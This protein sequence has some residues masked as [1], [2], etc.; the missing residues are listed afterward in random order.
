VVTQLNGGNG[1]L[2]DN[3]FAACQRVCIEPCLAGQETSATPKRPR[4]GAKS[5]YFF[6]L[7]RQGAPPMMATFCKF[8]RLP[9]VM[10]TRVYRHVPARILAASHPAAAIGCIHEG[11]ALI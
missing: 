11:Q 3:A 6:E 1:M 8:Q 10:P 7:E 5:S 4:S 9:G 2:A